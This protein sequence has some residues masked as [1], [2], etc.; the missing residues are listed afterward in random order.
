MT[1]RTTF[2]D[3]VTAVISFATPLE[4][5]E[6]SDLIRPKT[7]QQS[8]DTTTPFMP[9]ASHISALDSP[10]VAVLPPLVEHRDFGRVMAPTR[11]TSRFG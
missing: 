11:E 9:Y 8:I 5:T 10:T 7:M 6:L 4:R 2:H 1:G 3:D